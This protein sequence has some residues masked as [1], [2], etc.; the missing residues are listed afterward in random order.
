MAYSRL[1]FLAVISAICGITTSLG[2]LVPELAVVAA[3]GIVTG[4]AAIHV[5]RKYELCGI[6][7]AR[8]GV[9]TSVV[10]AMATPVWH[11]ARFNSE[12][13]PGFARLDF[14]RLTKPDTPT[15]DQ[16]VGEEICLKGYAL[17]PNSMRATDHFL[18]SADGDSRKAETAVIVD[19]G[20]DQNWKWRGEPLAI[21]G[22]LVSNPAALTDEALPKFVLT[23]VTV[24]PSRTRFGLTS[25]VPGVGC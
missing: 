15:L 22:R 8:L 9:I 10:F 12:S 11:V 18:F 13:L 24:R 16:F 7:L 3:A 2:L 20:P 23:L 6:R 1:S 14:A 25:R 5:I 21:S 4:I 19:L 17:V